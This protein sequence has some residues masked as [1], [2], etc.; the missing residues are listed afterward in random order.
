MYS[1]KIVYSL[2]FSVF[3]I[4]MGITTRIMSCKIWPL[5]LSCGMAMLTVGVSIY[6][7]NWS[8]SEDAI[9]SATGGL[10]TKLSMFTHIGP[11]YFLYCFWM[12]VGSYL[13]TVFAIAII[14][15]IKSKMLY[16]RLSK[17]DLKQT[18]ANSPKFLK[19]YNKVSNRYEKYLVYLDAKGRLCTSEK[20][21]C[22]DVVDLIVIDINNKIYA[23][24]EKPKKIS[25]KEFV[26]LA[27]E[28]KTK[29]DA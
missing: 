9:Y 19:S 17:K 11:D 4:G 8:Y 6:Y 10:G 18:E 7:Y 22:Y 28:Y 5:V 29:R 23:M 20:I 27:S 3:L 1:I 16:N 21:R 15:K 13:I 2:I 26:L 14:R 25:M 24:I 12:F